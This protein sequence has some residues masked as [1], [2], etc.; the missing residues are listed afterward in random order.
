MENELSGGIC[1]RLRETGW[2]RKE[3]GHSC[4]CAGSLTSSDPGVEVGDILKDN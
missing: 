2:G 3:A 1:K 4:G